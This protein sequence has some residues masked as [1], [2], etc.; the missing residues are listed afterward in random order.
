MSEA[1]LPPLPGE[2]EAGELQLFP[3]GD[4]PLVDEAPQPLPAGGSANAAKEEQEEDC[5]VMHRANAL[6]WAQA[7]ADSELRGEGPRM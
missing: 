3:A 6:Q 7:K 5:R 4:A 2:G 1:D